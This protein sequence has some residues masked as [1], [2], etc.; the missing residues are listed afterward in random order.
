MNARRLHPRLTLYAKWPGPQHKRPKRVRLCPNP[1]ISH[2]IRCG[3]PSNTSNIQNQP[4]ARSLRPAHSAVALNR[5]R[6]VTMKVNT[7]RVLDKRIYV[8]NQQMG[9]LLVKDV[10]C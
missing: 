3:F 1:H 2:L 9:V 6:G 4:D 10:C 7:V 5:V 8:F